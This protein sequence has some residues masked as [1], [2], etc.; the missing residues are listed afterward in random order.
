MRLGKKSFSA[1]NIFVVATL[2][3]SSCSTRPETARTSV[4]NQNQTPSGIAWTSP[5]SLE[6][7]IRRVIADA[8]PTFNSEEATLAF[9]SDYADSNLRTI[10]V[11]GATLFLYLDG[12]IEPDIEDEASTNKFYEEWGCTKDTLFVQELRFSN[13]DFYGKVAPVSVV[14]CLD[15]YATNPSD[16][17]ITCADANMGVEKIEWE[18]W[19]TVEASGRGVFYENDCNPD[20]AS[21]QILRQDAVIS[22]SRIQKDKCG[23]SVFTES[24][25][26]TDKK[27][28]A[29]GYM[30]TYSLYFNE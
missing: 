22:L 12:A 28:Q 17:I 1:F 16:I 20:C 19:N 29:G 26:Q 9:I 7:P 27:Q 11:D 18:S 15:K 10:D 13:T 25:V 4:G 30:D 3:L 8:C 5:E 14:D 2:F 6:E 23:K 24:V 21:G